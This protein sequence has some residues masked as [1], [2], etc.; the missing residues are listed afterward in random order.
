MELIIFITAKTELK[1]KH[2]SEVYKSDEV[3]YSPQYYS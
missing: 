2:G 3:Y 1:L